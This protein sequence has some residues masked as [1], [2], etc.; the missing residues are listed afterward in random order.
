MQGGSGLDWTEAQCT[1]QGG[2]CEGGSCNLI[3]ALGSPMGNAE[4]HTWEARR[5]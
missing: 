3:S 1:R 2:T 5:L 4:V